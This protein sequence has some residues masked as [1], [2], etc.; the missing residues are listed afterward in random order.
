MFLDPYFTRKYIEE[1]TFE[2]QERISSPCFT[3]RLT[4]FVRQRSGLEDVQISVQAVF[5]AQG[6]VKLGNLLYQE[7]KHLTKVR[8][9]G[10]Y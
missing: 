1:Y 7:Q 4:F 3:K 5:Q 2:K 9:L 6:S 10:Q 8:I